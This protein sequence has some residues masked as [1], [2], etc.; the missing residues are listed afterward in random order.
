MSKRVVL[1]VITLLLVTAMALPLVSRT[2]E[3]Q[4]QDGMYKEAPMLADKVA[5]GDLPPVEERLPDN[6]RVVPLAEGETIG[7]YG[8]IWHRAWRGV[9]DFHC[10]GRVNYDPTLRWPPILPIRCSPAWLTLGSS[11]LMVRN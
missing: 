3:A 4:A 2:D 8:G 1:T 6:P 10:Y 9:N 7:V 11:T 5:A